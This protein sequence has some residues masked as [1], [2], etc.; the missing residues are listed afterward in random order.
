MN[1]PKIAFKIED[2]VYRLD[3]TDGPA[4]KKIPKQDREHLLTLFSAIKKQHDL[5]AQASVDLQVSTV[6]S[7]TQASIA[8]DTPEQIKVSQ[9][10]QHST[11]D[12][13]KNVD[14]LDVDQVMLRLIA[15]EKRSSTSYNKTKA[16]VY[17]GGATGIILFLLFL[18]M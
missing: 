4:I 18:M 5:D 7:L 1:F 17:L 16:Y 9:A 3:A 14:D 6:S 2:R 8:S 10:Y 13:T 15:Q 12:L 11:K